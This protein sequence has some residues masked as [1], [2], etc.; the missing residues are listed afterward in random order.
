MAQGIRLTQ[1]EV[2]RI[3]AAIAALNS[4]L[5]SS[6]LMTPG[7]RKALHQAAE[8]MSALVTVGDRVAYRGI[9]RMPWVGQ[10][11]EAADALEGLYVA[12]EEGLL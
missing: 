7:T 5:G 1:Q 2:R 4:L 12:G 8:I 9:E 6:E 11:I 10:L 3:K